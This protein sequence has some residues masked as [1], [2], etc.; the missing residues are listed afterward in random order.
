MIL[1]SITHGCAV[2]LC[3]TK[4]TVCKVNS[5]QYTMAKAI[6]QIR[7]TPASVA[8]LG[9][10]G[11]LPINVILD[12]ARAKY[13]HRL[14]HEL[15]QTRLC[16]RLFDDMMESFNDNDMK[17]WPYMSEIKKMLNN[18]GMDHIFRSTK[19]N[20]MDAFYKLSLEGCKLNFFREIVSKKSLSWYRAIKRPTFGEVY[21]N[22]IGNFQ[23]IRLKFMARTG[24][25]GLGEDRERWGHQD[26][27]CCLCMARY[28]NL[29]HF[30]F[31]CHGLNK[32]RVKHYRFLEKKIN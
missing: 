11:W 10:L 5:I 13:F 7:S 16:C 8:T 19:Q 31:L 9:D 32:V 17:V 27:S 28:E 15:P 6:L 18:V 3:N 23:G 29:P 26:L 25:L 12:R 21:M 24:C 22:D 14:K 20:W 1:P 4:E 2:W 30:L